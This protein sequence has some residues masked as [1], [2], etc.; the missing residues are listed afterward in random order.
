MNLSA[1]LVLALLTLNLA[2]LSPVPPSELV[3]TAH[4]QDSCCARMDIDGGQRCPINS[5]GTSSN[6][7]CCSAQAP[8]FV[9]YVNASDDFV[10]R[11]SS[12]GFSSFANDCVTARSQ[13]PPVPPPR[14]AVS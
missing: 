11:I 13:R 2:V 12:I 6:S 3:R 4:R 1:R 7:T 14:D 9:G 8:C 5:G 10:V